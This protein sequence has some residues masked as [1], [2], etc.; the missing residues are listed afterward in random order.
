MSP[1]IALW[2][3]STSK[4]T[5]WFLTMKEE[6][7]RMRSFGGREMWFWGIFAGV[8]QRVPA[9]HPRWRRRE[10]PPLTGTRMGSDG[11]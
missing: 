8:A 11:R 4:D 2:L 9:L 1:M 7:K 10:E 6:R 5:R 3:V